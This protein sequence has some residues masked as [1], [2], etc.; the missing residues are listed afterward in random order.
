MA[1]KIKDLFHIPSIVL[2][3]L[4]LVDLLRGFMHTFL[5]KW[6]AAT[7]A[8]LDLTYSSNDQL[9]LLGIYGISKQES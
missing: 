7:F 6:S 1:K 8:Q 3:I 5:L 9:F 4:G 2:F